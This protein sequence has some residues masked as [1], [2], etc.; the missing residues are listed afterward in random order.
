[1]TLVHL[2][3][4]CRPQIG[5]P[6]ALPASSPIV[7][8]Q[9]MIQ[10]QDSSL[11]PSRTCLDQPEPEGRTVSIDVYRPLLPRTYLPG[12]NVSSVIPRTEQG[13]ICY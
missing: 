4:M 12:A 6:L 2:S 9:A 5:P 8:R 1:M 13:F 11:S 10:V 7:H 3:I